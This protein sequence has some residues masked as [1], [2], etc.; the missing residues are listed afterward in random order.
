MVMSGNAERVVFVLDAPGDESLITG[1]TIARLLADGAEVTVLFAASVSAAHPATAASVAEARAALGEADPTKWRQLPTV[2]DVGTLRDVVAGAVADA[3]PTAVIV[4]AGKSGLRDAA[5]SAAGQHEVPAFIASRVS[6]AVGQRLTAIDVSDHLDQKMAAVRA[7]PGRFTVDDRT[8]HLAGG[9]DLQINGSET[10][11]PVA[12]PR[13]SASTGVIESDKPSVAA[14]VL[15]G[16]T[17][18]LAG[19]VFGTLGTIAH[20]TTVV[21]ADVTVPVGLILALVASGTLMLGLRLV[22]GDRLIV[23]LAGIGLVATVFVL[24]L[25]STGGSVLVPE[26]LYGTV[27]SM[28][29][30]LFAAL[31]IAWPRI[32]ARRPTA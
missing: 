17:A 20:Q 5:L 24:S 7:Y 21:I 15:A 25:R 6:A 28:A 14:R 10:Y 23:L 3:D 18:I 30:A 27:W 26:G 9:R 2:S 12:P 16:V 4:A 31:V 22:V 8:V 11:T 1:G 19:V 32:P 29:P 13:R